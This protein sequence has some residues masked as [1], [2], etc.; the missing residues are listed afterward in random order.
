MFAAGRAVISAISDYAVYALG[1]WPLKENC[2]ELK[3]LPGKKIY[4]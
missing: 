2:R 1:K 4:E 3:K